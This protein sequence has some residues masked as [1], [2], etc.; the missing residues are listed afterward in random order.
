MWV[1]KAVRSNSNCR[2]QVGYDGPMRSVTSKPL[3][4]VAED[5]DEV[6]TTVAGALFTEGE[7]GS[8]LGGLDADRGL[9]GGGKL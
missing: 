3:F 9:V 1:D 4:F 6:R 5:E 8:S 7:V 2:G